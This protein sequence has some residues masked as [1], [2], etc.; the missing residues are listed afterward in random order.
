MSDKKESE[1]ELQSR[2]EALSKEKKSD[3]FDDE[4]EP[5]DNGPWYISFCN[6]IASIY[7]RFEPSF[8]TFFIVQA[9]SHGLESCI[10]ICSKDYFKHYLKLDPGE[11]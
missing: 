11:M 9:F 8:V 2:L 5:P 10:Y 1:A 4:A 3:G 6:W 7:E